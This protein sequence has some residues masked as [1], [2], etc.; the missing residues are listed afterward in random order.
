[1]A[2]TSISETIVASLATLDWLVTVPT[3]DASGREHMH[4]IAW[5]SELTSRM[6]A[7]IALGRLVIPDEAGQQEISTQQYYDTKAAMQCAES[8]GGLP[9]YDDAVEALNV[10]VTENDFEA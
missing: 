6:Q 2:L 1:M 7:R 9:D 8:T 10:A 3:V 4:V 5:T